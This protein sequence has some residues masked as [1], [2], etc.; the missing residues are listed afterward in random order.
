[1][2]GVRDSVSYP[3]YVVYTEYLW[4]SQTEIHSART[5][6]ATALIIFTVSFVATFLEQWLRA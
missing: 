3:G 6:I 5:H 4:N 1:M 2:P